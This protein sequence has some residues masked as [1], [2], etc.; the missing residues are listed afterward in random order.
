[1]KPELPKYITLVSPSQRVDL[2]SGS[3]YK[4]A[5]MMDTLQQELVVIKLEK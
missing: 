4:M 1:M 3:W 2:I 5:T